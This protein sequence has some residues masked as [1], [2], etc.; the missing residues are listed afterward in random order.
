MIYFFLISFILFPVIGLPVYF[1]G[2]ISKN[3][4]QKVLG[5]IFFALFMGVLGYCFQNPKTDPDLVRYIEMVKGYSNLNFFEIFNA[6][7]Y[8][9]LFVIDIWFWLVSQ[10]GNYQLIATTA[11]VFS[12]I[13]I[14][15]ILQDYFNR[16]HFSSQSK[17][18]A[19]IM[20]MGV[21]NFAL[22][23]NAIR[24]VIAFALVL[25]AVYR[26]LYQNKKNIWTYVCY[27]I[28]IFMHFAT[29]LLI[30]IRLI[31]IIKKRWLKI[32][33][34]AICFIP[35]YIEPIVQVINSLP[36]GIPFISYI[37]SFATRSLMYFKWDTGGWATAVSNSGYYRL[38]KIY[39]LTVLI[40]T[41]VIFLY[42]KKCLRIVWSN[43]F[44]SYIIIYCAITFACFSMATPSYQRF[45][46][47]LWVF[48]ISVLVKYLDS[49]FVKK[50]VKYFYFFLL[51][52]ITVVGYF[53]NGYMLNTMIPILDFVMEFFTF[54]WIIDL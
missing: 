2:Y 42:L 32:L 36:T 43:E 37:Q 28:P 23:V 39:S 25:F 46:V 45:T 15:Y 31:L 30:F 51:V 22:V 14:L 7:Q 13:I 52:A 27:I 47:P 35:V 49:E 1:L 50:K 40:V 20:I 34:V 16:N 4:T 8:E 11:C 29:I 12:Y 26:E 54:N 6:G 3:K 38:N 18:I 44:D 17:V 41:I 48:C 21:V 5:W 33:A 9:N 10:T 53:L 24:S 19:T